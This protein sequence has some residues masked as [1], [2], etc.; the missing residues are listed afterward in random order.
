[1]KNGLMKSGRIIFAIPF[2]VFGIMHFMNAEQ[3]AESI[4]AGWPAAEFFV[5]VSGLGLIMGSV[6]IIIRKYE[7]LATLLLALE[8]GIFIATLHIPGLIQGDEA[9]LPIIMVNLLKD[10]ALMG[11]ALILFGI[12]TEEGEKER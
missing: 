6:S 8:L 3:M 2:G 5:Y 9:M 12:F 1:M 7:R 4:L 10:M 11:G